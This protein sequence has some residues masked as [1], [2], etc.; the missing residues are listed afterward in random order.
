MRYGVVGDVHGNLHALRTALDAVRAAG[1]ETILCP[2]DVVGYGPRPDEC[3]ELLTEAGA[4]VVAGNHDLMAI[5]ELPIERTGGVVRTTIEWTRE[6]ISGATRAW[7]A[8]LPLEL[9]TGDGVFMTHG[10]IGDP[11]RY[12]RDEAAAGRQLAAMYERDPEAKVLLLGHTH[13][14]A[15]MRPPGGGWLV[16]AGSV[17]QSRERRPVARALVFDPESREADFLALDYDV[18]A[19]KR[20]L[21]ERGL[22]PHA[23]HLAPG[24]LARVRRRVASAR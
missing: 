12:I 8:A 5:G 24:R 7:L 22:P 4:L 9:R 19:T 6:N 10:A 3:V 13:H 20:E 15:S 11:T 16:N 2:G 21:R 14:A 17:G 23:C 1:A 18:Q